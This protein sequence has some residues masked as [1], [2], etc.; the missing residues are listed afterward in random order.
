MS[1]V[2]RVIQATMSGQARSTT[3]WRSIAVGRWAE[4]ILAVAG[5]ALLVLLATVN[6]EN[7]PR[8]WFD[9]GSHLHVPKSLVQTGVYADRSAE[10]FRY[11]G[12]SAGVGPTV[13][14]PIALVFWLTEIGLVPARLVMVGYLLVAV[15]IYTGAAR[16]LYGPAT[17]FLAAA[18]LVTA[19]PLDF[20]A[21][22]RQ[23]L[24]EVPALA[25]LMLGFLCWWHATGATGV[26]SDQGRLA[27]DVQL[28]PPD[29][30][31]R[32]SGRQVSYR[33]L[34]AASIAFGLTALTK[35]QF[36][37]LMAPTWVVMAILNHLYY[38]QL[39]WRAF[40]FPLA[41][42]VGG[43]G[44]WILLQLVAA[45]GGTGDAGATLRLLREASGGAIFVFSPARMLSSL[46]FLVGPDRA[47]FWAL[48]GLIYGIVLASQRNRHG[49]HQ[50]L[51]LTL[52]IIGLAWFAFG[53]IGWPRYAF[54]AL[55]VVNLFTARFA[56]D[57]LRTMHRRATGPA[58]SDVGANADPRRPMRS[59]K[60]PAGLARRV[61]GRP[62]TTA[63][64]L[65]LALM[66]LA[67]LL[68]EMRTIASA[69][70]RDPQQ[71]AAYLTA[72]VP[73]GTV[74]ETWEPELGFLSEH[75]YHYPPSGWLDRAVRAKWL[76]GGAG[77]S[78][79]DPAAIAH[80]AYLVIG[81][82]GKFSGLYEPLLEQG[83]VRLM[84]S[85]GDYDLYQ[86]A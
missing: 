57:L 43:A 61:I 75:R 12:P 14:V 6:L 28:N 79:Y 47:F 13:L 44:L 84:I 1:Q 5:L 4:L 42:V 59:P 7:Y 41:G 36:T 33:W 64:G 45:W 15:I 22:G 29:Q 62:L 49:L 80:P 55:A 58:A 54:P 78:G 37:L 18:L 38:R 39:S 53:S 21:L 86:F 26:R 3:R 52:A 67:P 24:G 76:H 32:Q 16:R 40:L 34:I 82:F 85:I 8:T 46:R 30:R 74:I 72:Q 70:K 19:P 48:P 73:P 25:F 56:M 20:I 2:P 23:V 77:L 71:M 63:A 65:I 83:Q 11:Y 35:N 69:N 60:A 10:G 51:P 27:G 17:A 81:P 50:A 9:E 66:V 31:Y 68:V